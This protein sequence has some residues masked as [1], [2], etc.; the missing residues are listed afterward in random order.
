[1]RLKDYQVTALEQLSRYLRDLAQHRQQAEEFAEFQR[2]KGKE[3][4]LADYCRDTW[5]ALIE[6]RALPMTSEGRVPPYVARVDGMGRPVPNICLKLPTGGGKTLLGCEAVGRIGTE[7][8]RKQTG[9]VL[10]VVPSDAIYS[11]TWRAFASREHA[12]R[13]TLERASGGRVKL[14]E[15]SD[16]FTNQDAGTYLCVMLL[17]LQ[18]SARKTKEQLKMFQDSGRY[19]SFFPEIDDLEANTALWRQVTNLDR[20]EMTDAEYRAGG[21][22]I[23]QSLGN[24][25]RLARPLIVIDEGHRAYSD[26]ALQTLCG[27][28]PR[29]ILEMSATPNSG[30]EH[31][32]N[33]VVNVKGTDLKKDDMIKLPINLINSG[34]ADWKHALAAAHDK[35]AELAKE[36]RKVQHNEGRYIR[37]ILL[38]RVE[39]TGKDQRDKNA[40]HAED[41][42]EHLIEK[43]GVDPDEIKVKSAD[44][45]ELRD[46]NLLSEYSKVRYIITKDALREGWDCPFAYVLAILSKTTATT[47]LTQMVGRVLRQPEATL[48]KRA[49]LNEC[50]VF[51]YEQEVQAAVESVR[52][53]LMEE[54][55]GDLADDVRATGA[56]ATAGAQRIAIPRRKEF[57][58]LRVFLPRV[59]SRHPRTGEWRV[60]DYDRDL[61]RRIPWDELS[62]ANRESFAPDEQAALERT[63]VRIEVDDLGA[64]DDDDLQAA[65][66]TEEAVPGELDEPALVRLLLDVVPNPWQGM[67]I[68][69]ETLEAL[70]RRGVAAERI[71]TNRLALL[72]EVRDDLRKQVLAAGESEFRRMMKDSEICFRL[73]ASGDPELNWEL[74][75]TFELDVTNEDLVLTRPSGEYLQRSLFE[76]VYQ[77]QVNGLERDVALYVD[78]E[79]AVRWWHRIAVRQD[80]QLQGWQRTRVYPDFLICLHEQGEGIIRFSVLETKG[81]HLKGNEDTEYKRKFLQLLTEHSQTALPVGELSLSVQQ[82]QIRF[83]LLMSDDW[84]AGIENALAGAR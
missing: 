50:Y 49:A 31:V 18:A 67:R 68:L 27:F 65:L 1:M 80:W 48:T 52:R 36:A 29:L 28:N 13:Q 39:R 61:L 26:I 82:Q 76:K 72:K 54:G 14:L 44:M 46:E 58:K 83:S 9:L 71:Y 79:R 23:K 15:K 24:V 56:G 33:V 51:T 4:K 55:M 73:E 3:V 45:D 38:A 70:R 43:L 66:R 78:M 22:T 37:P 84:R 69:R 5:S 74:A 64:V 8:F 17:M 63:L 42:R 57:E 47:A 21:V 41:V 53:G 25:L 30:G 11:Q 77:K 60:F 59:L 81:L 16:S 2:S 34:R 10:W 62:Y 35:L 12:Y 19:T 32:S 40:I 6:A 75:R 7:Y 20:S